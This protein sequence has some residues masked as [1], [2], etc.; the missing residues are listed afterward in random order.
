MKNDTRDSWVFVG[1]FD[2]CSDVVGIFSLIIFYFDTNIFT[3]FNF[4]IDI[5]DNNW[6]V[7]ISD[8]E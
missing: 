3:V 6:V 8:D 2:F 1:F 4:E 7:A 5:F